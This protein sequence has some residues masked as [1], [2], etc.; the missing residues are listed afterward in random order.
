[1]IRHRRFAC[2]LCGKE[3]AVGDIA[4]WVYANST[5]GFSAGNFFV[6]E[7]DNTPDVM[8]RAK[9]SY[10]T[11]KKLSKQWGIFGPDWQQP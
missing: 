4:K 7:S 8:E 10:E 6:C 11:A 5:P 9:A 3:F 2:S 1:M